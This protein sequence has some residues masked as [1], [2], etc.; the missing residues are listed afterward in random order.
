MGVNP[1]RRCIIVATLPQ[2]AKFP[3]KSQNNGFKVCELIL[4]GILSLNEGNTLSFG[5]DLSVS[6][7]KKP[8]PI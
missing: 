4:V 6:S 7:I 1:C 5:D 3:T 2:I 8:T